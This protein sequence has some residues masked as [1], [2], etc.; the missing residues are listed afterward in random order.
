[1]RSPL[2][3]ALPVLVAALLGRPVRAE[4][5]P[6]VRIRFLDAREA[7]AAV[8]DESM[9]P[10]FS[11]LEP[12]EMAAKTGA[13]LTA[14]GLPAQRDECRRRYR[15]AVG[16]FTEAERSAISEGTRTIVAALRA[17]YPLLVETPWS[18][19]KIDSSIEGG[20]PHTRGPHIV[21]PAHFA[22]R[23]ASLSVSS[24]ASAPALRAMQLKTLVHEQVHVLQRARPALFE[25]FYTGTWG[26]VRAPGLP[27]CDAL[28]KVQIVNPDGVD[29]G[30]AFPVKEGGAESYVQPL[31][32][33]REAAGVPQ[34]PRDFLMVGVA[35]DRKE[36]SFAPRLDADG[37]PSL[38]PLAEIASYRAAF[39]R[40]FANFHPHETFAE[41]FSA[42][43]MRDHLDPKRPSGG[44]AEEADFAK[45]RDW[46]RKRFA[47]A[48]AR[49]R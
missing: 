32:I 36:A 29:V 6:E 12:A 37:K 41:M 34:M 47:A 11:I 14:E 44:A 3:F 23:F 7:A 13:A 9:E 27:S 22:Q 25:E 24:S 4:D 38:R 5:A 2:R 17:S 33:L 46:S 45:V 1:M 35:L 19:L 43:A 26:F 21:V 48:P 42:M 15:A 16:E 39:G 10:Y 28:R 31:V 20:M 49:A 40:V 8:V 30:W 18:F